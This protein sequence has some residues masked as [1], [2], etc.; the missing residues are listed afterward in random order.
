[1][2]LKRTE[3]RSQLPLNV[4]LKPF[5][6]QRTK[7]VP[8][9]HLEAVRPVPAPP[10]HKGQAQLSFTSKP[11]HAFT[12]PHTTVSSPGH[13]LNAQHPRPSLTQ[14]S[15]PT[16]HDKLATAAPNTKS[17]GSKHDGYIKVRRRA[18]ITGQHTGR[19]AHSRVR[20]VS[21]LVRGGR[22]ARARRQRRGAVSS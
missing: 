5:T 2:P 8:S 11:R 14:Y 18:P 1:M 15:S 21:W 9:Y 19:G 10:S 7:A 12:C 17:R 13:T 4:A 22:V 20:L 6:S 3:G 16:R